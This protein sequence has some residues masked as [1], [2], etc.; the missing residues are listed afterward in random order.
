M[1][2]CRQIRIVDFDDWAFL[3]IKFAP[4]A[5]IEAAAE[6]GGCQEEF[7]KRQD[8]D[9]RCV[10]PVFHSNSDITLTLLGYLGAVWW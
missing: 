9:M 4:H 3:G 10:I 1:G 5:E 6:V 7:E 2:P 8:V